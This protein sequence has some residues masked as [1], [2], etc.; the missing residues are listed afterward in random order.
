RILTV[1]H[2]ERGDN[3]RLISARKSTKN[4]RKFYENND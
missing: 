3:V 4:E 2:T 1:V